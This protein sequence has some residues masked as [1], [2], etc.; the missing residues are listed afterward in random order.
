M[1]RYF[2]HVFDGHELDLDEEGTDLA[3]LEEARRLSLI[4]A[5]DMLQDAVRQL[6]VGDQWTMRVIDETG[7]PVCCCNF[8][9]SVDLMS[10][11]ADEDWRKLPR[12]A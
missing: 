2:F 3:D 4:A 1:P 5:G 8:S 10:D 6:G 11:E 7:R 12:R 9:S